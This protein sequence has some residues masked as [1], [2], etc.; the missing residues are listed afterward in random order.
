MLEWHPSDSPEAAARSII[1]AMFGV[2]QYS[3][4]LRNLPQSHRAVIRHW[5]SFSQQHRDTVLKGSFR[6]Y[7]PESQYPLLEAESETE[8]IF[9]AYVSGMV[10]PCGMLDRPIYVLNG[11]GRD[12]VILELPSTPT[13]VVAFDAQGREVLISMPSVG[14]ISKIAVPAGG[15]VRLGLADTKNLSVR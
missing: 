11:T 8:R 12:E 10:V 4:M 2:I 14:G 3:M 15:Y 5:L 6:A 9:G 7:N 1:S 13:R